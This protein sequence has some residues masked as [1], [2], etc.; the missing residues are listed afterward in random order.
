MIGRLQ[1]RVEEHTH[2]RLL[3]GAR[4]RKLDLRRE[5]GGEGLTQGAGDPVDA[6]LVGKAGAHDL[7]GAV[8][9][10]TR[11]CAPAFPTRPA[12]TGSPAPWVS[13]SPPTSRRRSSFLRRAPPSNRQCVCSSTRR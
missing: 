5:V 11:S 10:P 8:A 3:G 2:W 13:P 9:E 4:L 12:S 6:G 7:V 1:R